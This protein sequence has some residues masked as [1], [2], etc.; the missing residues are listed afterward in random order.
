MQDE[1]PYVRKTA[2]VC[3]AKLFDINA[4]LVEDRGFL[5][6]LKVRRPW[7]AGL[8]WQ[9]V[10]GFV[11]SFG[12]VILAVLAR[13]A[14]LLTASLI[15]PFLP[16][17]PTPPPL[18]D[19]IRDANP[20]VV[21]NAVAALSEIQELSGKPVLLLTSATV[22]SLLRALNECTEWG[23]VRWGQEWGRRR[24]LL[25]QGREHCCLPAPACG[26]SPLNTYLP[27]LLCFSCAPPRPAPTHPCI[28][29]C[30]P[31]T[32]C[33]P[34]LQVFILDSVVNYTP[35]DAKDA[36]VVVERVLPRLPHANAAVV[37]SAIKVII[38]NM[39][40]GARGWGWG[41][42]LRCAWLGQRLVLSVHPQAAPLH[43][44]WT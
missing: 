7:V 27:L 15:G 39:Q 1:D 13:A 20:M 21:A 10:D 2:A 4:E 29:C 23:Q 42:S 35:T 44:V 28:A 40:V 19:L 8:L 24:A 25:R 36:E 16:A 38:K 11:G 31:S 9:A 14:A 5:D 17:H 33:P 26:R 3:V 43:P 12:S 6:M 22:Q 30:S 41:G 18:Q 34:R 37:L 32:C